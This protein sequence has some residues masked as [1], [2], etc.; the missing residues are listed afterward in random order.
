M[1]PAWRLT[2]ACGWVAAD[3][4]GL[5]WYKEVTDR[6]KDAVFT[7]GWWGGAMCVWHTWE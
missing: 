3:G 7:L 1:T 5:N 4:R 2:S 6:G